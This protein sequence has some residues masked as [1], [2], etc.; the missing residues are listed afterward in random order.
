MGQE[1]FR[2]H[3][4]R[5]KVRGAD[6]VRSPNEKRRHSPSVSV[7]SGQMAGTIAPAR[8]EMPSGSVSS[9]NCKIRAQ[10]LCLRAGCEVA[11]AKRFNKWTGG[12]LE[13]AHDVGRGWWVYARKWMNNLEM[14]ERERVASRQRRVRVGCR[15]GGCG[16]YW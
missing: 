11:Y 12:G 4:S 1:K 13:T 9:T 15:Q 6:D 16:P 14:G 3:K 5:P 7:C 10:L 8:A 2:R